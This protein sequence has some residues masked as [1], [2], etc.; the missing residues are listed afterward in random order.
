MLPLD[1]A[2]ILSLPTLG[3]LVLAAA[4]DALHKLHRGN[5]WRRSYQAQ[6]LGLYA[7]WRSHLAGWLA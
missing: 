3:I 5:W 4:I 6:E 2:A 7:A 1:S